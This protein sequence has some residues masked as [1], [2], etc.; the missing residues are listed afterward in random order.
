MAVTL[1]RRK[2]FSLIEIMIVSA[3]LVLLTAIAV[4]SLLRQ[5]LNANESATVKSLKTLCDALNSFAGNNIIG[6]IPIFST[7][8]QGLNAL[9]QNII[10]APEPPYL[11]VS[12]D[13]SAG[14][15]QKSGYTYAYSPQDSD[16]DGN[17]E[18]FWIDATPTSYPTT[19]VNSFYIDEQGVV[20]EFDNAGAAAGAYGTAALI[21]AGWT[22]AE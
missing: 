17:P 22:V 13:D 19:G 12:W 8:A 2:G 21:A 16:A 6:G 9:T 1:N 15:P 4:P 7:A 3:I 18:R 20:Y 14:N 11:D 10:G 5:R